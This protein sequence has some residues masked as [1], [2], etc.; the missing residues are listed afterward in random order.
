M[1]KPLLTKT[2]IA[3]VFEGEIF[4]ESSAFRGSEDLD[5]EGISEITV[6][7]ES[8]TCRLFFAK[9][10]DFIRQFSKLVDPLLEAYKRKAKWIKT[11]GKKVSKN[12]ALL[13]GTNT[14]KKKD[15][16]QIERY[17]TNYNHAHA[18]AKNNLVNQQVKHQ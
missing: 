18:L 4:G 3:T 9:S 11:T 16:F 15:K 2:K 17:L 6:E 13:A 5:L 7:C 14:Q 10:A 1:G 8:P 12:L